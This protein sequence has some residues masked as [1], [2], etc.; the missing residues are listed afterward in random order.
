LLVPLAQPRAVSSSSPHDFASWFRAEHPKVPLASA[1]A[2]IALASDGATVPFIARYR[3][4]RTGN[5]DEVAIR[6]ALR[7]KETWDRVLARKAVILDSIERQ[8]KLTPELRE[9]IEST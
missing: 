9:R 3:K 7:A 6:E 8:K 2:V 4:E 5:L 1:E